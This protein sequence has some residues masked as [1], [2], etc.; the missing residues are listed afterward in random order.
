MASFERSYKVCFDQCDMAGIVFF[1]NYL[2][3]FNRLFEEWF[4]EALKVS[5]GAYHAERHSGFPLLNLQVSFHKPSRVGDLLDW[6][7][8]VR[9]IGVKSV[10]LAASA[11]CRG[12]LRIEVETT[13]VSVGLVSEGVLAQEI[14]ADIRA[15][16]ETFLASG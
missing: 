3:M 2:V 5:L 16:M 1:P 7:L 4:G 6:R 14:P 8:Q 10:I 13:M 12:E 11:S 9:K 15:G